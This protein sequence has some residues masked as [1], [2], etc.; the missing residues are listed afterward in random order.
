MPQKSGS[1]MPE[2]QHTH[3]KDRV[4]QRGKGEPLVEPT[5]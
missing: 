3:I 4:I 1:A 2:C 5:P